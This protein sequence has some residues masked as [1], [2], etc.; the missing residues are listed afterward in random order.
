MKLL[1]FKK[2]SITVSEVLEIK[3]KCLKYDFRD[4]SFLGNLENLMEE[5]LRTAQ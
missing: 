1:K 5:T 4:V 2:H 3:I